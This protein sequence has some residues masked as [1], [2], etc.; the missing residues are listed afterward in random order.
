MAPGPLL[1]LV[2]SHTLRHGAREGVKIALAPLVTDMP[3]IL[4]CL[5]LLSRLH[6]A[7]TVLGLFALGGGVYMLHLGWETVRTQPVVLSE[8]VVAVR[9]LRRG[10]FVNVLSPSPYL[11][12]LSV[13][14]PLLAKW[15]AQSATA[16]VV[17]L[18][19][20]YALL[21]GAKVMLALVTGRSRGFLGSRAYLYIMRVLGLV[22]ALFALVL[23][24]E[25]YRLLMA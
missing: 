23:F 3:I 8:Q 25:A 12:W 11:F 24:R 18:V 2:V 17:F 13:G 6:D 7:G 10:V 21:V 22:L 20:F 14:M 5:L 16:L 19:T 4:A 9:S 1:A 15:W